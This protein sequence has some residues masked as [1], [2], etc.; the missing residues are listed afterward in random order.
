MGNTL[1]PFTTWL[2]TR[3]VGP[4][5]HGP[6]FGEFPSNEITS[7]GSPGGG[8]SL[9]ASIAILS[10]VRLTSCFVPVR[11]RIRRYLP[12]SGRYR[13]FLPSENARKTLAHLDHHRP[14]VERSRVRTNACARPRREERAPALSSRASSPTFRCGRCCTAAES[15]NRSPQC[16][17]DF[18]SAWRSTRCC[19]SR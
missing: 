1:R 5:L 19:R 11:C 6:P 16:R 17:R 12:L 3:K 15:G 14:E 8:R 18:G 13:R 7:E 4:C 9:A 2:G 10:G